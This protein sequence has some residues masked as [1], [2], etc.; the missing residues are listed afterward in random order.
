MAQTP[1]AVEEALACI[2]SAQLTPT[3]HLLLK[4][5]VESAV[6]PNSIAQHIL[7]T[8]ESNRPMMTEVTLRLLKQ[9]WR[10]LTFK[11]MLP[12]LHTVGGKRRCYPPKGTWS[13]HSTPKE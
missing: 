13:A 11:R 8:V 6:D 12:T 7:Q 9:D 3:E 4:D 5:L 10:K 2:A 1:T